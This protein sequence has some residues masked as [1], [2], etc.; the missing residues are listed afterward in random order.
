MSRAEIA[1][2]RTL[3]HE[4]GYVNHPSDPGGHTNK[5]ITLA[6]FR[7]YIKPFGSVA[8]LKALTTEQA[9]IVYKRQYWDAVS[10]DLLPA[11]VDYS[12]FDYA[13]NS[14]P[15]QAAKDLQRVVGA[16]VDGKVGPQTIA[17]VR[18]MDPK[19]VIRQLNARRLAF[20]KS[21]KGGKLWETFGRGWQR[22]V[23]R[24]L[25]SSLAD[26]KTWGAS[27]KPSSPW[28]ALIQAILSIFRR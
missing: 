18:E 26:T 27:E 13:V 14:G 1:I 23:D 16:T 12:V 7:R 20:M 6:T 24:V 21:L 3:E 22:R 28:A 4:G 9:T 5:G 19:A 17:A 8:D 15:S 10:A 11:G 2:P 25:A